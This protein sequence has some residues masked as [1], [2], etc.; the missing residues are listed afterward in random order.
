MDSEANL[1]A[2][3]ALFKALGHPVRLLI[4]NLIDMQP[5]HGEELAAILNLKAATIS[6]HLSKLSDVGLLA[7]RQEQ[8][9]HVYSLTGEILGKRLGEVIRLPQ[10]G[11]Q[12][13]VEADA[14]TAK[15]LRT[16]F[17]HGRLRQ[18]P[19]QRKKW[20]ILLEH[21]VQEFD[22]D[23]EYTEQEVNQILLDFNEDVATL[24][25]SFI[26]E[27]LM[28]RERGIYKRTMNREG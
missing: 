20:L 17:R 11:L 19:A 18:I 1:A 7:H 9:Y 5:R 13:E 25:R 22:P 10:L 15:V 24:R 16:F 8:Y 6:H 27:K 28:T 14:Y 26:E 23:R 12:G 4:L 2:R 21:M 3:A